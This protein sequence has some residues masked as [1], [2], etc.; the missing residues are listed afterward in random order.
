MYEYQP[1]LSPEENIAMA[2]YAVANELHNL[3][4]SKDVDGT[5]DLIGSEIKN[6]ILE[7]DN[8]LM[9]IQDLMPEKKQ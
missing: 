1:A 7:V 3:N 6:A 9:H 2:I 5:L 8:T 4:G